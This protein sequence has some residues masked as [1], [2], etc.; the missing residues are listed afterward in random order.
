MSLRVG[1]FPDAMPIS[2]LFPFYKV[3]VSRDSRVVKVY[4]VDLRL[5]MGSWRKA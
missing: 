1:Y 4:D 3:G 2:Y 5:P